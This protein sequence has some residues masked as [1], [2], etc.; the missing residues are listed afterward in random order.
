[1]GFLL[2]WSF[3]LCIKDAFLLF[4][5]FHQFL[6]MKLWRTHGHRA[7]I[8][9]LHSAWARSDLVMGT[10]LIPL[11]SS[12]LHSDAQ[13]P[14][15]WHLFQS[16]GAMNLLLLEL[17]DLLVGMNLCK[18]FSSGFPTQL[19]TKPC[20]MRDPKKRDLCLPLW[21]WH[22]TTVFRLCLQLLLFWLSGLSVFVCLFVCGWFM[23]LVIHSE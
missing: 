16:L 17:S 10:G 15:L 22:Q 7:C 6:S 13:V 14:V 5:D 21:L 3:M 12:L 19:S 23:S 1:M 8:F 2:K 20:A 18:I 4:V 9:C 11:L